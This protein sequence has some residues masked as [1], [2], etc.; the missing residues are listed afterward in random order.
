[1]GFFSNLANSITGNWADVTV[2]AQPAVRGQAA[3][4]S[5]RVAVKSNDMQFDKI[6]VEVA[7]AE[8]VEIPGYRDDGSASTPQKGSGVTVSSGGSGNT[9]NVRT[10]ES[11]FSQEVQVSGAGQLAA[12]AQQ[13]YEGSVNLPANLPPSMRG[14]HARFEWQVRASIVMRGNDPDSGWQAFEV[15]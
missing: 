15:R 9:V 4:F 6:V 13:T 3:P 7:C 12:N 10:R 5:V 14:R 2:S 1:M 11:L 8:I